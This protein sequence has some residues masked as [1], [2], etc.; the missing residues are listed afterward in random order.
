MGSS[1]GLGTHGTSPIQYN[2]MM[3]EDAADL[4]SILLP[5]SLAARAFCRLLDL[6][7]EG[8]ELVAEQFFVLVE[9]EATRGS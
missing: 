5:K 8:G 9:D 7:T 3:A 2:G 4:E 1:V 6:P